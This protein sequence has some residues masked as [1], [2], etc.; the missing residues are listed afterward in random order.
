MVRR[1]ISRIFQPQLGFPSVQKLRVDGQLVLRRRKPSNPRVG[2][3]HAGHYSWRAKVL[4]RV[5]ASP[6]SQRF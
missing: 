6:E 3:T 5:N 1:A 2:E 4:T